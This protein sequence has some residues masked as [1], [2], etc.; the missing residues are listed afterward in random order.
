MPVYPGTES[1]IIETVCTIDEHGFVER[2]LSMFSHVGTHLD[3]PAHLI[4]EARSLSSFDISNFCGKAFKQELSDDLTPEIIQN[5][6]GDL[7]KPDFILFTNGWH[8]YWQSEKYFSD[9]PVPSA[10]ICEFLAD[11][12]VK[13]VGIDSI[14]IDRV[15][16]TK[17]INHHILLSKNCII[18]ENLT[19]MSALPASMFDFFCF[20]LK[21]EN[22]DG[23]PVRAVALI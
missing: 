22:G 3:V 11:L 6:I 18:I 12:G 9:F 5:K 8:N 4:K 19:N 16:N 15:E 14:S 10:R 21:I 23:S 2:K 1:P 13:G 7:G 20:P 17:L